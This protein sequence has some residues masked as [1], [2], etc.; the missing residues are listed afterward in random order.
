MLILPITVETFL[1]TISLT[2]T[3]TRGNYS[4]NQRDLLTVTLWFSAS[5]TPMRSYEDILWSAT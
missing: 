2:C 5:D 1:F 3:N 4:N